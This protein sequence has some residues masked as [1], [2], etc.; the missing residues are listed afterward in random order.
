MLGVPDG[1][2]G[3]NFLYQFL[4][5][6]IFKVHVPLGQASL[7]RPVLNQDKTDLQVHRI[8]TKASVT[9][10]TIDPYST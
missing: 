10:R 6:I 4:L 9:Y 7:A 3:V 8:N 2:D 5:L 1:H